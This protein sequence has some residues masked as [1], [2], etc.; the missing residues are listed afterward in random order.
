[1]YLNESFLQYIFSISLVLDNVQHTIMY[2]VAEIVDQPPK[3]KFITLPQS[4]YEIYFV[5][6]S[7]L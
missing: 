5:Q 4:S 6:I 7:A 2:G 1:M 3:S